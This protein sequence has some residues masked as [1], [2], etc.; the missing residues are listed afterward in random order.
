MCLHTSYLDMCSFQPLVFAV[1]VC[2]VI[3]SK[4]TRPVSTQLLN[5]LKELDGRAGTL[6]SLPEGEAVSQP[7][8]TSRLSLSARL[9][10]KTSVLMVVSE[11]R[12]CGGSWFRARLVSSSLLLLLLVFHVAPLV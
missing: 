1:N 5:H 12:F 6:N 11:V 7:A 2:R 9:E 10:A 8:A 4:T 3:Q